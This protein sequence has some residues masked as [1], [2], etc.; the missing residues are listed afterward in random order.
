MRYLST[1][2]D[3]ENF[4][5]ANRKAV[6]IFSVSWCGH[7]KA[8][9]PLVSESERKY[10]N[11]AFACIEDGDVEEIQ[12]YPT[13]VGYINGISHYQVLGENREEFYDMLKSL[14]NN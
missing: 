1:L 14:N 6:I 5:A 12:G 8:M 11:I 7:C 9:K 10:P 3:Q 13:T 2:E 4:I